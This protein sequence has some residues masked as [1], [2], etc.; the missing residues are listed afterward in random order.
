MGELD[1]IHAALQAHRV[2]RDGFVLAFG[3]GVVGDLAGFA[4]ATWQR[5][6]ALV[7]MPTTLLSQVDSSVGGKVGVNRGGLKNIVGA[8]HQP[9]LVVAD[10][11][12]LRTTSKRDFRSGMA[13]IVKYG[14]IADSRLFRRLER[15]APDLVAGRE[16]PLV[17]IVAECCRIKARIVAADEFEQG[18]R[19]LLNYGHTLG[20]ALEAASEGSLRHG[21]AVALGMRG[22]G[23][24]AVKLGL[25]PQDACDRQERLLDGFGLPRSAPRVTLHTALDKLKWDKKIRDGKL[26]F[27]LTPGV[28]SASL[29]PP[30]PGALIRR[31]LA[32]LVQ[33]SARLSAA[34][35]PGR[36]R[37]GAGP[38]Q[39]IKTRAR[40]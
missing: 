22:A 36:R 16:E 1:R 2:G 20:H 5:G 30:I 4:A 18:M 24:L 11:A 38:G 3:G 31:V 19:T 39:R 35:K 23:R 27:V 25:M 10:V 26:R 33:P 32:D 14:M 12:L 28:G 17:G 34:H 7:M 21:E 37:I 15:N 40:S 6:I 8:F 29:S 13:E 9:T